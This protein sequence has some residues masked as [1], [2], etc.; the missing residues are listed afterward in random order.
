MKTPRKARNNST[1]R[2][3]LPYLL[4][5]L[6][7]ETPVVRESVI[8]ALE[9][10]GTSLEHSL[11]QLNIP[12]TDIQQSVLEP[13]LRKQRMQSVG[14]SWQSWR[15]IRG[16]KEKLE[17]A[18]MLIAELQSGRMEST[19]IPL[20]LDTLVEEFREQHEEINALTLARF[21][22]E[23]VA[24]KGTS[25]EE[26][27]SPHNSNLTHVI[28]HKSG[29]PIS[30]AVIYILTGYRLNLKIEGCNLPGHFLT[31]ADAS[32]TTVVVDC[33]N[34]GRLIREGHLQE[35]NAAITLNDILKL[36]C[37][38]K[39]IVARVLRNLINAYQQAGDY[40]MANFLAELLQPPGEGI[41]AS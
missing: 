16:E 3:Q 10:Y 37:G 39:E 23:E 28:T 5:L 11:Y 29:I 21:L 1:G 27:F 14:H 17:R 32:G 8:H 35:I 36:E 41:H 20:L 4:G 34:C 9:A 2:E 38:T 6:D 7:D 25:N 31:I 30:L 26:Y 40:P 33:F 12:L 24:L 15:K 13:V 18:M 19:R 22:F